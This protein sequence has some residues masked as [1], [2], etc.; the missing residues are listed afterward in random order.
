MTLIYF[1][2]VLG[3]VVCIHEFGHFLFAKKAGIYVYEFSIGMGPKLFQFHRK[4]DET[5][6]SI[7]LFPIGG[8]VKMAGEEVEVDETIPVEKR[9]GSKKWLPKVLTVIAGVCFNFLLAIV[10]FFIVALI[11]GA[12]GM[13][14]VIDSTVKGYPVSKTNL[15]PQDKVLKIDGKRIYSEDHF[16]VELQVR[17][18]KEI[19]FTVEHKNGQIETISVKPVL[20]KVKKEKV[21]QYG[22]TLK[23]T[24]AKGFLPALKYAFLKVATLFHQMILIIFYLCTGAIGLNSMS[25]PIGIFN[26]VGETAKTGILNL[27]YLIGY[28]SV[29]VGFI[30]L[31]PIPAFDGGRLL[32][33]VIEKITGKPVK[34]EVENWIHSIGF[35]LLMLLMIAITWN[36]IIRLFS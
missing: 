29:N 33:L 34:P 14:P 17:L 9:F 12:P 26:L 15:Q 7:R 20:K 36:D 4:N 24:K 30:N 22:F 25:G 32:F 10:I 18:G 21:Y 3:I 13:T 6:Y 1:I 31:L 2:L 28:L 11:N 16:L 8:Y 23:N 27:I 19:E 35:L 5:T